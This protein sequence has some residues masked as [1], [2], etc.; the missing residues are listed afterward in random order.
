[1]MRSLEQLAVDHTATAK[2]WGDKSMGLAELITDIDTQ[3]FDCVKPEGFVADIEMVD[4][5]ELMGIF[6]SLRKRIRTVLEGRIV[7]ALICRSAAYGEKSG[8][9]QSIPTLFDSSKIET[10]WQNFRDAFDR[11][12]FCPQ[13]P[14]DKIKPVL[15]QVLQGEITYTDLDHRKVGSFKWPA[16]PDFNNGTGEEREKVVRPIAQEIR[17][18]MT[19][20][21]KQPIGLYSRND[22][23]I[24]I[25]E[26]SLSIDNDAGIEEAVMDMYYFLHH[27]S[28]PQENKEA[29]DPEGN[30]IDHSGKMLLRVGDDVHLS[31]YD[32]PCK[33]VIGASN[34]AFVARSHHYVQPNYAS[35]E[36]A[37]GLTSYLVGGLPPLRTDIPKGRMLYYFSPRAG[38]FLERINLGQDFLRA[39]AE[40]YR[41]THIEAFSIEEGKTVALQDP[42]ISFYPRLESPRVHKTVLDMARFYASKKK[43]PVELEGGLIG[44]EVHVWQVFKSPLPKDVITKLTSVPPER[45]VY[46][47]QGG[48]GAIS[49]KGDVLIDDGQNKISAENGELV[50]GFDVSVTSRPNFLYIASDESVMAAAN[51][52]LVALDAHLAGFA[53]QMTFE[54]AGEKRQGGVYYVLSKEAFLSEVAPHIQEK[55]GQR[56]IPNVCVEACLE[57]IQIYKL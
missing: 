7:G 47:N 15:M 42:G 45:M 44:G 43:S 46:D 50:I 2:R 33:P 54:A 56:I 55:N 23:G 10:S 38:N 31:V 39:S 3:G 32:L 19:R 20:E 25:H 9:N 48:R 4:Y 22:A 8:V 52:H 17:D 26:M 27:N 12:R 21:K 5:N 49:F 6:M 37:H 28:P 35:I 29:L 13:R 14:G 57:G 18:I 16:W 53:C 36:V 1:M 34:E 41:Q 30:V 40:H 11:V 24:Q 51:R